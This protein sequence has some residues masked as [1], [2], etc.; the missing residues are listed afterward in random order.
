M[1]RQPYG[2]W[3]Q[4]GSKDMEMRVQE[5]VKEILDT[6]KIPPLPDDTLAALEKLKLDGEK[7]LTARYS[8]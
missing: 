3:Q 4:A 7:E 8:G 1:S 2:I 5:K 6:H